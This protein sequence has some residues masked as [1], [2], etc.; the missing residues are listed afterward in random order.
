LKVDDKSI[1]MFFKKGIKNSVVIC[2]LAIT[3][4]YA[5]VEEVTLDA[6]ELKK[7]KK[8]SQSN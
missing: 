5:L 2:K 8:L 4:E 7:D 3:H 6:R 1:I